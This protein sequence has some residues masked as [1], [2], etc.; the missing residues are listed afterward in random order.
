MKNQIFF[1]NFSKSQIILRIVF[2]ILSFL[3]F[4]LYFTNYDSINNKLLNLFGAVVF[5]IYSIYR[6]LVENL[7]GKKFICFDDTKVM[8]K[9]SYLKKVYE[10][11][12]IEIKKFFF[13][14]NTIEL[15]KKNNSKV[16]AKYPLRIYDHIR[17]VGA[18]YLK[19]NNIE[20]SL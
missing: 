13:K 19:D 5:L 4:Y 15:I 18:K 9:S 3:N 7:L 20:Y 2:L 6:F 17:T 16:I 8:L 1:Y 10:V 11:D 12:Y 14:S